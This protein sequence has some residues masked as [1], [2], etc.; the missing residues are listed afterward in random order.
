[1]VFHREEI[2]MKTAVIIEVYKEKLWE[3][4]RYLFESLA[5]LESKVG[6]FHVPSS[7]RDTRARH[8]SR[9]ILMKIWEIE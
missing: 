4:S 8:L 1:M 9:I 5:K 6:K 2:R 3:L 7:G